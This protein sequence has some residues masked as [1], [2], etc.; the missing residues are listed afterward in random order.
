MRELGVTLRPLRDTLRDE[1][2]WFRAE[3]PELLAS[4]AGRAAAA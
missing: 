2:A 3:R 4:G 1:I